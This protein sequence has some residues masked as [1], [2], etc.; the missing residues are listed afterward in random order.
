MKTCQMSQ[1]KDSSVAENAPYIQLL[2]RAK[3]STE[4]SNTLK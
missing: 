3:V 4:Q 1:S 2:Y